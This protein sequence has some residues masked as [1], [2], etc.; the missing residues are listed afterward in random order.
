[1]I[2]AEVQHPSSLSERDVE[3]WRAFCAAEPMF[4]SSLLGPDFAR[5]VGEVR[6]DARVAVFRDQGETIAFLPFHRRGSGFARPIGSAFSD[7]HALV[8]GPG[9]RLS[10]REALAAAGLNAFRHT[11]LIDPAAA[12]ADPCGPAG[13]VIALKASVEAH[14]EALRASNPKRFK[15]WRRLE[16][17]LEREVGEVSITAGEHDPEDFA[18]LL[19]WKRE[20]FRRTGAHDVL[21]PAWAQGLFSAAFASRDPHLRGVMTTL[22]AG[23]R[24]VA[25]HFGIASGGACHVW[26]SA[27]DPECGGAGPGQVLMLHAPAVMQAQGLDLYDLG[28]GYAHYK[29]PFATG[30][31]P[32][33]EGIALAE[34]SQS[35]AARSL[36]GAW[37]LAGGRIDAVARLRRRLD[38]I[39]AADLSLGGRVRGVI[40]AV[41]G[42]GRRA[43]SREPHPE[44]A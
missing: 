35:L 12:D 29:A 1:M 11:G 31:I 28:P 2:R 38:Q 4:R 8:A 26:I 22:R 39:A 16:H 30:R 25:G 27:M 32:V 20:Q 33:A 42:Q 9:V 3:L 21:R 17:K 23:G 15:N 13:H 18:Q 44:Q 43:A 5:L 14:N 19:A 10:L 37:S 41:A 6:P 34:G 40:E 7:Y 24:L 36:E